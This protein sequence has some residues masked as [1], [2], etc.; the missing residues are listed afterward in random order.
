MFT[1]NIVENA[2][3]SF[4]SNKNFV[5]QSKN[6]YF[7]MTNFVIRYANELTDDRGMLASDIMD[8][9]EDMGIS[10]SPQMIG[11]VFERFCDSKKARL[12]YKY[13]TLYK[14]KPEIEVPEYVSPEETNAREE[15]DESIL[16]ENL[17][18]NTRI[19]K[20]SKPIDIYVMITLS[21]MKTDAFQSYT[22]TSMNMN[23]WSTDLYKQMTTR[24]YVS[25]KK[26]DKPSFAEKW[27]LNK[28]LARQ[29]PDSIPIKIT[30]EINELEFK[31]CI[32]LVV[33]NL[34]KKYKWSVN[35]QKCY[36]EYAEEQNR[37]ARARKMLEDKKRQ[38]EDEEER[39]RKYRLENDEKAI[40][41]RTQA[42]N[43][44]T[45]HHNADQL[46]I[47]YE[48]YVNFYNRFQ[49]RFQT[50][51]YPH[52]DPVVYYNKLHKY[53][54]KDLS[55]FK[56]HKSTTDRY[57]F[58][59]DN[60]LTEFQWILDELNQFDP[61]SLM[62]PI[63]LKE[64][65]RRKDEIESKKE[66][67]NEKDNKRIEENRMKINSA[68]LEYIKFCKDKAE[69]KPYLSIYGKEKF[70]KVHWDNER[71]ILWY[72]KNAN[73]EDDDRHP[74][75][76]LQPYKIN[77]QELI[78]N[79]YVLTII[80]SYKQI[81]DPSHVWKTTLNYIEKQKRNKTNND[82]RFMIGDLILKHVDEI[83]KDKTNGIKKLIKEEDTETAITNEEE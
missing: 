29:V 11:R 68:K 82:P 9:L 7:D 20:E 63:L 66:E 33:I 72:S 52:Y 46:H 17:H 83:V 26:A 45:N 4:P 76:V 78:D 30:F 22:L 69:S 79:E 35:V 18:I 21:Y 19:D 59:L 8:K 5:Y 58:I 3:N 54:G 6:A 70:R 55:T 62:I 40:D 65:K 13:V 75:L 51:T 14:L 37:L 81:Q 16:R 24:D 12:D 80:N 64:I 48:E 61:N 71:E 38:E 23:K 67:L 2:N 73:D 56:V 34:D 47:S 50:T 39:V 27:L 28:R 42:N 32:Q 25:G 77:N 60:Y 44:E 10:M 15:S 49:S 41:E 43:M 31:A 1:T 57:Y 36:N 74:Q 53:D